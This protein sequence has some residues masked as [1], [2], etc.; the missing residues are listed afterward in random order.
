MFATDGQDESDITV[1]VVQIAPVSANTVFRRFNGSY[2]IINLS[3]DGNQW[4]DVYQSP[5]MIFGQVFVTATGLVYV[6]L[7]DI[8][9]F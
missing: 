2:M 7:C 1:P 8:S 3:S 6:S 9:Q 4:R 5:A